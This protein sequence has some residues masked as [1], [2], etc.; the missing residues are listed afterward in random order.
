MKFPSEWIVRWSWPIIVISVLIGIGFAI[1]LRWIEI[2]P[3]IK[4]QLPE[5]MPSRQNVHNIEEKFGGSELVMVVLTADDVLAPATLERV[6]KLGDAMA[7]IPSVDRVISPFTLND[8]RGTPDGM[9]SVEP[10]IPSLPA[11]DAE[12]DALRERLKSNDLV[13]GNVLARDFTAVSIIGM[14]STEAKDSET[15]AG[16][17]AAVDSVPGPER[18]EIGG[19]PDVR[20]HV[21]EDIRSDI[22]RFAPVGV[23]IIVVFL[24]ITLRQ[25]RG[26]FVPFS[27]QVMSIVVAMGLIPLLG[28]KVQM[29]T[30]T[31]P[32]IMLAIG[33]DHT[34][35]LVSRYQEINVPGANLSAPEITRRVLSELGIPV[36]AAGTTTVAGMLCLLTH[37]VVPAA[38]LGVLSSVGLA[39]AMVASLTYA[40][41]VMAKLPV[42]KPIVGI[43]EANEGQW[44]D[45]LLH[46]NARF[47]IRNKK[48]VVVAS[49]AIA[50]L[51]TAGLPWLKVDTNPVN[52]YPSDAPVAQTAAL[53]NRHFG[54]STEISVMVEGDIQD[55]AVLGKIDALEADLRTMPQVG[56][57]MSIARVVRT[58]NRAVAGTGDSAY[59]LPT[60]RD[61][62]AQLF[63]LYG[64]SG[65]TAAFERMVDFDYRHAL[66]TARINSLSTE[67]ISA[68]VD[69]V[70]SFSATQMGGLPVVVGGFGAVFSELVD[71]IVDGQVSSLALSFVVVAVLDAVCFW[72]IGAGLW[73]MIPLV[74]SVPALF[75][76]MGFAGIELNVVTAMLS[77]IMIGVGVDYTVHFLWRYREER[78]EGLDA[79]EAALKALTT[80]G[81]GIVFNAL[82]VILGFAILF[83]SNFLPVRFF[84]FLVVVSIGACLLAA[85]VLMPPLVVLMRPKFA[86]PKH[87]TGHRAP[88]APT[89]P[90]A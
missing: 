18:I 69:R 38:Q 58:M 15:M 39:F 72:S 60:T 51:A 40:P 17:H 22:R 8:I 42:P 34:V 57:T 68:V 47:V 73:S 27:T 6:K 25:P 85:L 59:A 53:I 11:T 78:W 9:M 82:S 41:A 21:S 4:N 83:L 43:G 31:L 81:R 90:T 54:G 63:L 75:G 13:F 67:E 61:G 12:R 56:Y 70:Q 74:L 55:P 80:T 44:L 87:M 19:M 5:H 88:T 66:V 23:A 32:V 64:M 37:V 20:T 30:V 35:H 7:K 79:E 46:W 26:V 48:T 89:A 1:P 84:G 86:E 16:V 3:E 52:Y 2:D 24:V 45:R 49:F 65:D 36:I 29:V 77:S 33:N 76:L 62:V 50:A 14:L 71:A 28:W 10:A